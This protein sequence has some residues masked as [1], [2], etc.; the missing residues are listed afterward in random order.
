MTRFQYD[1]LILLYRG[2]PFWTTLYKSDNANNED[3]ITLNSSLNASVSIILF[4][5]SGRSAAFIL[6]GFRLFSG[7]GQSV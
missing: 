1:L 4:T 5:H 7:N 2:L 6:V 3:I